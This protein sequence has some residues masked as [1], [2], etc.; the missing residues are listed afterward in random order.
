LDVFEE[1]RTL[2]GMQPKIERLAGHLARIATLPTVGDARQ[3]GLIGAVELVRDRATK[4]PFPW[5][6]KRGQRVCDWAREQGVWLR[7]LGIGPGI[8]P[9]LTITLD[10]LDRICRAVEGGIAAVANV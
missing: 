8:V 1:E 5:E 4:E 7:P 9:P 10:E 2:E 3:R 6:E